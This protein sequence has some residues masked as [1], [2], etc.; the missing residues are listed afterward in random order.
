MRGGGGEAGVG[1]RNEEQGVKR[2]EKAGYGEE[3]RVR[4]LANVISPTGRRT[5]FRCLILA[6]SSLKLE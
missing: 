3:G 4:K 5:V 2:R 6:F 1:T